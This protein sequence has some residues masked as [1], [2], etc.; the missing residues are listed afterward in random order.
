MKKILFSFFLVLI[1]IISVNT[2]T[3]FAS[4][5]YKNK[6]I[7]FYKDGENAIIQMPD[8]G[9]YYEIKTILPYKI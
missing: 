2:I 1:F 5:N 3:S 7:N 8:Y 4:S 9:I 6:E